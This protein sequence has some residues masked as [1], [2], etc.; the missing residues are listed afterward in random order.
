MSPSWLEHPELILPWG[1]LVLGLALGLI[2]AFRRGEARLTLLLGRAPGR[3]DRGIRDGLLLFALVA[4]VIAIVGPRIGTRELSVPASGLDLV[5]LLDLSRSMDATDNAPSRLAR[6]QR[7]IEETLARLGEGDRAALAVFAGQAALL[8]PLTPDKDALSEMLP[9]LDTRLMA[10]TR[11]LGGAG[12]ETALPG[13]E[14]SGLRPRVILVVS[15]G[16]IGRLRPEVVDALVEQDVRVLASFVGTEAGGRI[17]EQG[18]WMLDASGS[19]V[20]TRR[21]VGPLAPLLSATDGRALLADEWGAFDLPTVVREIRRDA[22]PS[23]DGMIKRRVPVTWVGLPAALALFAL[24]LEAWSGLLWGSRRGHS[25]VAP[26]P[27]WR[28][29][30]THRVAFALIGFGVFLPDPA[31]PQPDPRA[32]IESQLQRNPDDAALLVSLGLERVRAGDAAEAERAFRAAALRGQRPELV[33]LAWYDLGVLALEQGRLELARDAFFDAT[34]TSRGDPALDRRIKFNLEWTLAALRS[35][36]TPPSENQE[37]QPDESR[38]SD[39]EEESDEIDPDADAETEPEEQEQLEES[40]DGE[41]SGEPTEPSESNSDP[42]PPSLNE[43]EARRWLDGIQDDVR[44]S[45]EAQ[46]RDQRK[47][48]PGGPRW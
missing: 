29:A 6:A 21:D 16:E 12:F 28:P 36:Q 31:V 25:P 30:R 33:A 5:I 44:A 46:L 41:E 47:P 37:P 22:I 35:Q 15:D 40:E 11:S 24:C 2:W 3:R 7:L 17:P 26:P 39:D 14:G 48:G 18:R 19:P 8:T 20:V 32:A 9:A 27:A 4:T 45:I 1:L 38:P 23:A 10:D 42:T 43:E 13:F 34:T